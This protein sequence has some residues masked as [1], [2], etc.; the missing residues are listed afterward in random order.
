MRSRR[1]I[2][3]SRRAASPARGPKATIVSPRARSPPTSRCAGAR[4]RW[5]ES[6]ARAQPS[7]R[8]T[9]PMLD[10]PRWKVVSILVLL[11]ALMALAIPSFIPESQTKNWGAFPHPRINLGLDL[12]G[13]SYLLLE[14]DTNELANS[15][16]ESMRGQ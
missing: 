10:F 6:P 1:A 7:R 12:A 2:R 8:T 11:A 4:R 14:A 5:P 16:L 3:S 9:N 13:G 15:R